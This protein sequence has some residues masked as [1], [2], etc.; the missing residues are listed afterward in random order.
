MFPG[1]LTKGCKNRTWIQAGEILFFCGGAGLA[2]Y[3]FVKR[4]QAG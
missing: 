3:G 2:N 1:L 4:K